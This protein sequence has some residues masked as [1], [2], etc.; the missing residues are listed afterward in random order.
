M[1][2]DANAKKEKIRLYIREIAGRR[3]NVTLTEIEWVVN[4]LKGHCTV[5]VV[6]N[7]HQRVYSIDGIRFGV[8]THRSG[9]K[10]IKAVYVKEFLRVMTET[11][12]Y[13]D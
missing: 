8:C 11:G 2:T 10:Q 9:G 1:S 13:E 3:Q 4:Q 12:W 6:A 5:S 7:D